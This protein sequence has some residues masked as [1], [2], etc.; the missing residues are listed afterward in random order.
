MLLESRELKDVGVNYGFFNGLQLCEPKTLCN[1][2]AN[3][4]CKA[5]TNTLTRTLSLEKLQQ[6]ELKNFDY[7]LPMLREN[8]AGRRAVMGAEHPKTLLAIEILEEWEKQSK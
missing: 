7:G 4:R 5:C 8:V 1:I 6:C 3:M 2:D